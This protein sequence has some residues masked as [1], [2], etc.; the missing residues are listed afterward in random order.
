MRWARAGPLGTR[1]EEL[2]NGAIMP[3]LLSLRAERSNPSRPARAET[4]RD[5]FASLAMTRDDSDIDLWGPSL[6]ACGFLAA[7]LGAAEHL[8]IVANALEPVVQA[9]QVG[10]AHAAVRLGGHAR[11]I[12]ADVAEMRLGLQRSEAGF[13]GQRVLRVACIP[14]HGAAGFQHGHHV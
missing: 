4:D 5:C 9:E 13:I 10:E 1:S 12:A 6:E 2:I 3:G 8:A 7:L 14:D 11:D